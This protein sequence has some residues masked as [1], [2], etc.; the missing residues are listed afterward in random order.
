[1]YRGW[2][3][4]Y[5][6]NTDRKFMHVVGGVAVAKEEVVDHRAD[7]SVNQFANG[8]FAATTRLDGL[9]QVLALMKNLRNVN[10]SVNA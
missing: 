1:M 10:Y 2:S 5:V 9:E 7:S 6:C 4:E 3:D 8:L